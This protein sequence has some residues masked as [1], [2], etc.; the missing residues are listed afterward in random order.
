MIIYH[1][2]DYLISKKIKNKSLKEGDMEAYLN[3]K[4][5]KALLVPCKREEEEN[6]ARLTIY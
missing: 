6:L 5:N 4:E 1:I 3:F 2:S